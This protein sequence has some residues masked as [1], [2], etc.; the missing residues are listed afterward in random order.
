MALQEVRQPRNDLANPEAGRQRD[1]EHAAQF[2]G[3]ARGVVG[4]LQAGQQR[5]DP[6]E[7]VRAGVGQRH[8]SRG[9]H[10]QR[11]P[12]LLFQ[13]GQDARDRRLRQ[14]ELAAGARKAAGMRGANEGAERQ[15]PV[16]HLH[17]E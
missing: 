13:L 5:F 15:E 1:A 17:R 4:L 2:S 14:A 8:M 6:G 7:I 12:D 16:G 3:A 9:P 10:Q 11:R